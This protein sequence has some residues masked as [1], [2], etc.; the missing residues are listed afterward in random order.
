MQ[1]YPGKDATLQE[2]T[3]TDFKLWHTRIW[4]NIKSKFPLP[5]AVKAIEFSEGHFFGDDSKES[6]TEPEKIDEEEI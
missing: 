1:V 6:G 4:E 5:N 2:K 3:K